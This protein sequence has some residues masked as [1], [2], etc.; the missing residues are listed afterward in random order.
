MSNNKTTKQLLGFGLVIAGVTLLVIKIGILF[1]VQFG[2]I[3]YDSPLSPDWSSMFIAVIMIGIG[4]SV[5]RD[6][7]RAK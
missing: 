2:W 4:W 5:W 3:T 1:A 6:Q 7:K